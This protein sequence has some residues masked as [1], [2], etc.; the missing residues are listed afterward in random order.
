MV[1]FDQQSGRQARDSGKYT[2][3]FIGL[4]VPFVGHNRPHKLPFVGKKLPL[5]HISRFDLGFTLIELVITLLVLGVLASLA[6]PAL[7]DVVLNNRMATE[8]NDMLSTFM[9]A[10]SEAIKRSGNVVI[11]KTLDPTLPLATVACNTTSGDPWT[12]GWLVF[13]DLN[14]NSVYDDG[15]D[16]MLRRD[17]GFPGTNNKVKPLS[18]SSMKNAVT[19]TRLGILGNPGSSFDLCDTRGV[20]SARRVTL[21]TTGRAQIERGSL[22]PAIDCS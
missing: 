1:H 17:D 14:T 3:P 2:W 15:T 20:N 5:V 10:R 6:A 13:S 19:F 7:R 9:F 4:M 18:T 21:T 16:E 22:T 8:A 12:T 11:C